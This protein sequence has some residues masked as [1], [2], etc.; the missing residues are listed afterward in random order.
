[1]P[2]SGTTGTNAVLRPAARAADRSMLSR[3]DAAWARKATR[4]GVGYAGG[5]LAA[6]LDQRR[7]SGPGVGTCSTGAA[8][9]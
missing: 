6:R 2:A 8:L 1:M 4:T 7:S 3:T 9:M 5:T